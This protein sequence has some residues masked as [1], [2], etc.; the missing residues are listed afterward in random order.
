MSRIAH[1]SQMP[2]IMAFIKPYE[3]LV[4]H[5]QWH[6]NVPDM[7]DTPFSDVGERIKW[8]RTLEGLTQKEYAERAG[9]KRAQLSNWELGTQCASV[10]GARKLRQVYGLSMDFIF[11]GIDEALPMTLRAAWRD[12]PLVK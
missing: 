6:G 2:P 4:R 11:D 9:I 8:H 12:S 10:V 7:T 5:N 1:V 3:I